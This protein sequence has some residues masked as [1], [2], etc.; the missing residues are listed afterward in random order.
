MIAIDYQPRS[1]FIQFHKRRQ[2]WSVIV[3][4]R[5]CGKTVACVMD[6]IDRALR[7]TKKNARYAYISPYYVQSK[8]VAW[9]YFK[10]F[11][12]PVDGT[13]F[14]EGELRVNFINGSQIQ[15]AGADNYDRLRGQYFDG[16]ILDEYADMSPFA[17]SEVI[18][19]A[20][21]DRRGFA[22]F[23]GTPK[24]RNSFFDLFEKA[25]ANPKEWFS[26]KLKA[27]QTGILE[28]SE[29]DAARLDMTPEQFAQE[30]EC[31]F[32]AAIMGA[33]YA[34]SIADMER[35]GQIC[36]VPVDPN[37]PCHTAWDL[38]KDQPTAI[39]F[40]QVAGEEIH[41]FDYY[42]SSGK[43]LEHYVAEIRARNYP[44][45]KSFLPHDAKAR[46]LG[47][48]RTRV[49]QLQ[50]LGLEC[51][52]VADHTV[53]DGINAAR[54]MMRNTYIDKDHCKLGLECLRQYRQDFD[55]KR[56]T[57]RPQPLHDWTSHA[58]DAWRYLA[59]SN[60]APRSRKTK[61]KPKDLTFEVDKFG[62]VRANMSVKEWAEMKRK[63]RL[64]DD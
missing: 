36:D 21:A 2:R 64:R 63:K 12:Y 35:N 49:E 20:L 19:P 62:A 50:D 42:E 7:T 60:Y 52:I 44:S 27:S 15:L 43:E 1:Q 5:R 46:L 45:G 13:T 32:D 54:L 51:E 17:W 30:F 16:V 6:L 9:M 11:S 25:E 23:I 55:E 18:R 37:L 31:S 22:V 26:L 10:Q 56:N 38:G 29:L 33:F 24:G 39:W 28:A 40:F 48:H 53:M 3:A 8:Q 47:M 61:Q 4:H 34:A 14:N 41:V 58:S 57:F 59:M